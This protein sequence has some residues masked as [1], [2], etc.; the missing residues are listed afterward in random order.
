MSLL[1]VFF[2]LFAYLLNIARRRECG[3]DEIASEI[4]V[5]KIS[6]VS[7]SDS[8]YEISDTDASESDSGISDSKTGMTVVATVN[9]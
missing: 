1:V 7:S 9:S 8:D 4:L 2:Y 6:D 5:M 3:D